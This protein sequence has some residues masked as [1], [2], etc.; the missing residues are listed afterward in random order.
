[1]RDLGNDPRAQIHLSHNEN[2]RTVIL[3]INRIARLKVVLLFSFKRSPSELHQCDLMRG[4]DPLSSSFISRNLIADRKHF[5][6]TN[7]IKY[8]ALTKYLSWLLVSFLRHSPSE[9]HQHKLMG[10]FDPPTY[11]LWAIF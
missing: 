5:I 1:M 4:F 11:G 7:C 2:I 9:L 6:N 10:G 3:P 8:F